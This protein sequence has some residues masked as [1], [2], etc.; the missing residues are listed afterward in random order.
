MK[1]RSLCGDERPGSADQTPQVFQLFSVRIHVSS[2]QF[3]YF[4]SQISKKWSTFD[5]LHGWIKRA[6]RSSEQLSDTHS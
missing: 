6:Y 5:K 2:I 1:G 3:I 4:S